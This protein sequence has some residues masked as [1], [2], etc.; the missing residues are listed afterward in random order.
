MSFKSLSQARYMYSKKPLL[1][2]EF[3]AKTDFSALKEHV[4]KKKK[5][6]ITTKKK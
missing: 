6:K 1:A 4:A 3:A 2:K 5:K